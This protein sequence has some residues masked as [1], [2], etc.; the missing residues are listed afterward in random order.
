MPRREVVYEP[1]PSQLQFHV[2]GTR[3]KG[4][5]GPVGSGKTEALCQEALRLAYVNGPVMGLVGAP[6]Y[7]MLA[8]VTRMKFLEFLERNSIPHRFHKSENALTLDECGARIIFR[9]LDQPT[10]LVGTTLAWFALDEL[11]YS[12][13]DSWRRLEA[14][15]REPRAKEPV[16]CAVWTPKGFDWVYNRFIGPKKVRGYGAIFARPGENRHLPDGFYDSLKESYDDR[17]YKQEA[18]GEYLSVFAGQ[19]YYA[20]DR[21]QSVRPLG[22][23]PA[24]PLCW[25]L[26]FN[27]DP[28]CSVLAQVVDTSSRD[29]RIN[30]I[31]RQ[32]VHVLDELVLPDTRTV[33]HVTEFIKRIEPLYSQGLGA[34]RIFGDASGDANKSSSLKTDWQ[35]VKELLRSNARVPVAY[36][37]PA[38]NPPVRGRIAAVN[39][40]I[41]NAQG[42]RRL[43][44]DPKC[45]E[46]IADLEQVAWKRDSAG[47]TLDALDKSNPKRTHT[48]DALGYLVWA[49]CRPNQPGPQST[50]LLGGVR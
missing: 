9:S 26:D 42:E 1:L 25:S 14:R 35:Q 36:H 21:N 11:T 6:T 50:P 32:V 20:F 33:E 27:V 48:S 2:L 4:F 30:G 44:V 7:R 19:A 18:E 23:D 41:R 24:A 15:L 3:F 28:A 47:N 31:R 34:I 13:E 29:D 45:F 38:A 10:R 46:L 22:F 16:G 5:S 17:F 43:C 37:V 12:K 39:S 8:D 49:T 40:M